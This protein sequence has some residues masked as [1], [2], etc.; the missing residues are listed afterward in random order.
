MHG[1]TIER[2][3]KSVDL[4]SMLSGRPSL[5]RRPPRFGVVIG[6]FAAVPY[7]HLQLEAWQRLYPHAKVL[8]HDDGSEHGRELATLCA[9]YGADFERNT[10]RCSP[11]KGD[12]TAFVG[13][14]LW[15]REHGLDVLLKL[16]RRFVPLTDWTE[17]LA[18]LALDSHYATYSAW[19]TT[20]NFGFRTECTGMAVE[21]WFRLNLVAEMAHRALSP[22]DP[23]VE[24][25]V[26]NLARR[27]ATFNC[28]RAR[29]Y[30]ERVGHRPPER[31]GYA[32]WPWMGTDRRAKTD[33]F[34]WHDATTPAEYHSL[35]QAWGLPYPPHD[36]VDPNAGA[37]RAG[38]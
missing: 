16:S 1:V 8:V 23:F 31:N 9:R 29:K 20:Y 18:E 12:L 24:A 33:R 38:R 6:T 17:S 14:M 37:G 2:G 32:I 11:F 19:T 13:G 22:G 30:D 15:S 28:D 7:V 5:F 34:L 36:Y 26:H 4:H 27:A 35:G 25:F 3:G 10:Q 21:E